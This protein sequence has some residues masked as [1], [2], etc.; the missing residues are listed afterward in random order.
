[1]LTRYTTEIYKEDTDKWWL[2]QCLK[3]AMDADQVRA[4][5]DKHLNENPELWHRAMSMIV[6][7]AMIPPCGSYF[8][9]HGKE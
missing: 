3:T 9:S 4:I 1:M 7:Q 6:Y 2:A 8:D 5:V